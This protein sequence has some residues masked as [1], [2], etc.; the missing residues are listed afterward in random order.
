MI[1]DEMAE[2]RCRSTDDERGDVAMLVIRML[3]VMSL[4]AERKGETKFNAIGD[5]DWS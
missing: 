5:G 2:S 3:M 1:G 4:N